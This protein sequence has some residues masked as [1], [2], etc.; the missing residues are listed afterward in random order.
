M[1]VS[2]VKTKLQAS[3]YFVFKIIRILTIVAVNLSAVG[4]KS[5]LISCLFLK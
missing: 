3:F 5:H 2:V 1:V 4:T